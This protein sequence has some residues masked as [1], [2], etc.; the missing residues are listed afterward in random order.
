M[1]EANLNFT[2]ELALKAAARLALIPDKFELQIA[3][4]SELGLVLVHE[5]SDVIDLTANLIDLSTDE[6]QTCETDD[7]VFYVLPVTVDDDDDEEP[8]DLDM[9]RK[10]IHS[11]EVLWTPEGMIDLYDP[12]EGYGYQQDTLLVMLGAAGESITLDGEPLDGDLTQEEQ[13]DAVSN[14]RSVALWDYPSCEGEPDWYGVWSSD[15]IEGAD[16]TTGWKV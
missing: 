2:A 5:R 9:L 4:H 10:T 1:T 12:T 14:G 6:V 8:D 15:L 7:A 11:R 16:V 3:E 13:L